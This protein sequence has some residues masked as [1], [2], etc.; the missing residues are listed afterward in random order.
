MGVVIGVGGDPADSGGPPKPAVYTGLGGGHP[1]PDPRCNA[2]QDDE[3]GVGGDGELPRRENQ[4]G[5][6]LSKVGR[7]DKRR[8]AGGSDEAGPPPTPEGEEARARVGGEE[9][10][11]PP[12][13]GVL[14]AGRPGQ[15]VGRDGPKVP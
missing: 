14:A 7:Q 5:P 12:P 10:E 3:G 15:G 4:E 2:P 11:G 1:G 6:A 8:G 9:A 13:L